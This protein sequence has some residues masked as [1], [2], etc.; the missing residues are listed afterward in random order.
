MGATRGDALMELGEGSDGFENGRSS[1]AGDPFAVFSAPMDE[2]C[3]G[4]DPEESGRTGDEALAV[5]M[6]GLGFASTKVVNRNWPKEDDVAETIPLGWPPDIVAISMLC[7]GAASS[8]EPCH[9]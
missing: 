4:K 5:E 2:D 7:A 1:C 6:A 9:M 3:A 8:S